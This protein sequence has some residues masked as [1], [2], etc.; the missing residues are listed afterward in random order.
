MAVSSTI[1]RL[2]R[3]SVS[4]HYSAF[5]RFSFSSI[6]TRLSITNP[7]YHQHQRH[8]LTSNRPAMSASLSPDSAAVAP[9]GSWKS[10]ITA[11][12]VAGASKRL[13]GSALGPGGRLIWLESRPAEGGYEFHARS[14]LVQSLFSARFCS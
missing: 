4:A 9:Y 8:R 6:L 2:T 7:H 5:P 12:V 14:F 1:G 3:F 10:P 13:G 11:D